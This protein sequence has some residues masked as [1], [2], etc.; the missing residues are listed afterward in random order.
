MQ[1]LRVFCCIFNTYRSNYSQD[2]QESLCLTKLWLCF[3]LHMKMTDVGSRWLCVDFFCMCNA[4]LENDFLFHIL[5]VSL[6]V[7]WKKTGAVII[8]QVLFPAKPNLQCIQSIPI[9]SDSIKTARHINLL[10]AYLEVT[11]GCPWKKNLES[12]FNLWWDS[13]RDGSCPSEKLKHFTFR[14]RER[15]NSL[16][17][18][19]NGTMEQFQTAGNQT[20][21]DFAARQS[22][23]LWTQRKPQGC[24][25]P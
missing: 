25:D 11:S 14:H 20:K 16:G 5:R 3:S 1:D 2:I 12:S 15:T 18:A 17:S 8:E 24:H 19:L 10:P 21:R 6:P 7:V 23:S 22:R 4:S 13:C 9:T